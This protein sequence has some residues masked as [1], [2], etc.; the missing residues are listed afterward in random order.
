MYTYKQMHIYIY[1]IYYSIPQPDAEA[2][3]FGFQTEHQR[4]HYFAARWLG[5]D[6]PWSPSAADLEGC[7]PSIYG[8]PNSKEV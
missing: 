7:W 5:S 6:D 8:I 2:T 4:C 3:N 1:T